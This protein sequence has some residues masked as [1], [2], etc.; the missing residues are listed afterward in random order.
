MDEFRNWTCLDRGLD[1][2]YDAVSG[3][4]HTIAHQT[5]NVLVDPTPLMPERLDYIARSHLSG[6]AANFEDR[7]EALMTPSIL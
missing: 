4:L 5:D 3:M 2:E 7:H 1:A 6:D